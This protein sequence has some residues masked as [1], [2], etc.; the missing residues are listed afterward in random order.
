MFE[1]AGS[2][3]IMASTLFLGT[4]PGLKEQ[5]MSREVDVIATFAMNRL[6]LSP[7]TPGQGQ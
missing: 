3:E 6:Q 5:S 4:Y 2:Y 7:A 1:M